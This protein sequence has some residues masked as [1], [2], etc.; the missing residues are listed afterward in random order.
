ME[1]V[2]IIVAVSN[3]EEKS[4]SDS[5]QNINQCY[6]DIVVQTQEGFPKGICATL[7]G[8]TARD[9]NL[10]EG[11]KVHVFFEPRAYRSKTS[12]KW[13]T[14]CHAWRISERRKTEAA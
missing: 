2:G 7:K 6:R 5:R 10:P 13:F 11:T 8:D 14:S 4:L 3:L 12:G 1:F 9:F